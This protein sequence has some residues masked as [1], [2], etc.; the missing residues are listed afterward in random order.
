VG[1]SNSSAEYESSFGRTQSLA[2]SQTARYP[3]RQAPAGT[4]QQFYSQTR[5][6]FSTPGPGQFTPAQAAQM[7]TASQAYPTPSAQSLSTY[8]LQ[9]LSSPNYSGGQLPPSAQRPPSQPQQQQLS[10]HPLRPAAGI[11]P[12]SSLQ[13]AAVASSSSNVVVERALDSIL[14]S[15]T[16]LH[17]RIE[18]LEASSRPPPSPFAELLRRLLVFLHLREP[19]RAASSRAAGADR[20]RNRGLST[21]VIA[22]L[23]SLL[24]WARTV[25]ADGAALVLFL[26]AIA[27]L[28]RSRGDLT[29]VWT[30]WSRLL[31]NGGRDRAIQIAA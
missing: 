27:A 21:L 26:S 6:S 12:S 13:P 20:R 15:L 31:L 30:T 28:R 2:S 17:E 9:R 14:I 5:S 19:Q 29:A 25:L 10:P 1:D 4:Q 24:R 18:A 8:N 7:G 16:A 23:T 22:L 11:Y 3:G